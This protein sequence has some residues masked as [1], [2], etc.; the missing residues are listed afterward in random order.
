[1]QSS[2]F[3]YLAG[4]S[5]LFILR[6]MLEDRCEKV[7]QIHFEKSLI[8]RLKLTFLFAYIKAESWHTF[9]LR[10]FKSEYLL[11]TLAVCESNCPSYSFAHNLIC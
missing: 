9:Q 11:K 8:E 6:D 10:C 3:I 4:V 7:S 2:L 1:M 5:G